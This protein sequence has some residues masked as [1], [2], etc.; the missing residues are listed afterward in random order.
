MNPRDSDHNFFGKASENQNLKEISS[1][2]DFL[3]LAS[4]I[5][6]SLTISPNAAA[7]EDNRLKVTSLSQ[8]SSCA[9][10]D[11]KRS[12]L[13]SSA[14]LEDIDLY[15]CS[16]CSV[17]CS[18]KDLLIKHALRIHHKAV[19]ALLQNGSTE[20]HLKCRFCV[21]KVMLRHQKLLLL[22]LEKKHATEFLSFFKQLCVSS[23]KPQ[24]ISSHASSVVSTPLQNNM[25]A[26]SLFKNE[27]NMMK[28]GP[29][30]DFGVPKDELCKDPSNNKNSGHQLFNHSYAKRKLV[31]DDTLGCHPYTAQLM[32]ENVPPVESFSVVLARSGWKHARGKHFACGRCKEAF[33]CNALLLDHVSVRHRGPL[34][35]LQPLFTCGLC[36]ASFYKN[37]FL[38]RHCYRHHTPQ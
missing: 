9:N 19:V 10:M 24:D 3:L 34:R 7:I 20:Q 29:I 32:K 6:K 27:N 18:T 2:M 1:D 28:Q 4:H 36:S 35:L 30:F 14:Y 26:V 11:L 33:S 12:K 21:H 16:L 5:Q 22:H 15:K 8:E 17:S 37:S 38:V 13:R 25:A 31:L 23:A